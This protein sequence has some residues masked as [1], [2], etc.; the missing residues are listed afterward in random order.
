MYNESKQIR[1]A[2]LC[3]AASWGGLEMN[4]ARL[5]QWLAENGHQVVFLCPPQTAVSD[6]MAT[7]LMPNLY[8]YPSKSRLKYFD[9]LT[10]SQIGRI[11]ARHQVDSLVIGHSKDIQLGITVQTFFYNKLKLGYLQQMQVGIAKKDWLHRWMYS[12]LAFWVA[13][14]PSVASVTLARTTVRPEQIR[15]IPLCADLAKFKD[16]RRKRAAA[17]A[18]L[19]LPPDATLLTIVGRYDAGKGQIFL[20]EALAQLKQRGIEAEILLVGEETKGEEGT[21]L[22]MLKQRIQDLQLLAQVHFRP[23]MQ[24][25]ELAYAASD[26][27]VMASLEET[28]GM[29]T[30]E[31]MASALPVVG[32]RAGGTVD[33]LE[34]EQAG[35]FFE[36]QN[37]QSLGES[38]LKLL[39]NRMLCGEKSQKASVLS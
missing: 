34:E 17:R 24:S 25:I 2:F 15:L 14:L 38:L 30:I 31:A 5:A 39:Q 27:F 16:V 33:L 7:H 37:S 20:V 11:L 12:K 28:F 10:A 23:F 4:I 1:V 13:P 21:Y 29:V 19:G 26:I 36:P 6:F 9:L 32:S 22:P 8:L 18:Q 35:L 3:N